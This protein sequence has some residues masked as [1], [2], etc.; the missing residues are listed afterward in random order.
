MT[1]LLQARGVRKGFAHADG[2]RRQVVGG[3]D[4]T[5]CAGEVVC[6]LGASGSGKS[7]LLK[8]LAGQELP[9][10]GSVVLNTEH[11]APRLGYLSQQD[12]LMPWRTVLA[13]VQLGL[14]LLGESAGSL[15]KSL[16]VL[17]S[18]GMAA[19]AHHHP[20]Q[21][22]GGMQQRVLLART[23]ALNPRLL[24]L[25]EPMS[26]LDVLARQSLAS[27]VKSYS[28]QHQAA[29]LVVTH[30]VEEACFLA[31]R[32]LLVSNAFGG[33]SGGARLFKEIRLTD[34]A[35]HAM[36]GTVMNEL[37]AVLEQTGADI[38]ERTAA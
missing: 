13:N 17:E 27:L 5:L 11:P 36:M 18:V 6:L 37:L 10:A 31:D 4:L 29:V 35:R 25:D 24:L 21:L 2:Q 9:D 15:E 19:Y 38:G 26:S 12:Q 30:S 3:I 20:A 16:A 23:L 32:L 28:R 8:L 34:T 33:L 7:T 22:S 1:W 14:E